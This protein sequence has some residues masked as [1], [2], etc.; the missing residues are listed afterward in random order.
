MGK[1]KP[2]V[3]PSALVQGFI[4]TLKTEGKAP[5]TVAFLQGNLRRF[6]WYAKQEGWPDDVRAIDSWRVREFLAYAATASNRWGITGNGCESSREPSATGG[7]RYYRTLRH[8]FNWAIA[9]GLIEESPL[10]NIKVKPPKEKPVEPYT[11]E[12]LR[13][14]I[15]VCEYD[16]ANGDRFLGSRNKAIILLFVD[17]GL[18][19]GEMAGLKVFDVDLEKGRIVFVGKGGWHRVVA[20]NAGA[21]KALWRYML[22]RP[23]NGQPWLWLT[24][25]GVRLTWKGIDSAFSRIKARSGVN[26]SGGVHKLRHVKEACGHDLSGDQLAELATQIANSARRDFIK[27]WGAV[28]EECDNAC[29]SNDTRRRR[30]RKAL[31]RCLLHR[32]GAVSEYRT[33]LNDRSRHL[34]QG[35]EQYDNVLRHIVTDVRRGGTLKQPAEDLGVPIKDVYDYLRRKKYREK[36]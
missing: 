19:R 31:Q 11:Q 5:S 14:L 29:V 34:C 27:E 15:A 21:K 36:R 13:K 10:A 30:L 9:E 32:F 22:H 33:S 2:Q 3:S 12:E 6:L 17:T 25:E 4:L 23:N 16:F 28:A 18:R 8:L 24:E 7:W 20:F 26:G 1:K 35:F